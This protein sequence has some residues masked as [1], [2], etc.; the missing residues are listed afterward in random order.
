MRKLHDSDNAELRSVLETLLSEDVDITVREVAR[1]HSTLKNASAF[2][3]S[4]ARIAL[5]SKAKERQTDAR[6]VATAPLEAEAAA[7]VEV[8]ARE[9]KEVA[10]LESQIKALVAG[11][12]G[13]IRA[14]QLAGGMNALEKFWR[15][16]KEVADTVSRL[17][18][19]PAPAQ[20]VR[21][22]SRS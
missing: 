2:T 7:T 13:L 12:A 19:V 9:R 11:H 14:V 18:G 10:Q 1:R 15:D 22:V 17:G 16:Y 20:V 3:R 4:E 8:L 5:I 21:L 6:Q